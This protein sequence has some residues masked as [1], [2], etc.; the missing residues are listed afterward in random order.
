MEHVHFREIDS[1]NAYMRQLAAMGIGHL[2]SVSAGYQSAGKGQRQNVWESMAGE[3]I[4]LSMHYIPS[5]A[6]ESNPFLLN[7]LVAVSTAEWL[8]RWHLPAMVK[9]PNDIMCN[10]L[11]IA[12]LL[13]EN[14]L[15]GERLRR[16]IIG[17]GVNV[18][19]LNFTSGISA[20]SMRLQS[21]LTYDI[22]DMLRDLMAYIKGHLQRGVID[23]PAL[24][25][26]YLQRMWKREELLLFKHSSGEMIPGKPIETDEFG[27]LIAEVSGGR[28]V[29]D[30]GEV[31]YRL[32]K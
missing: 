5:H 32:P 20:T 3:N 29:F 17:I 28:R 15:M 10:N 1:T 12:G 7:K 8:E 16:S 19:Q 11:K 2:G 31:S 30:F 18:N 13:I 21:G 22:Y 26:V 6:E 24:N 27:R 25:R 4:L 9:W 23:A 14:S